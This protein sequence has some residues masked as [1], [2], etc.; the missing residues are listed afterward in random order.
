MAQAGPEAS[1]E[2]SERAL[3]IRE[4]Q[5]AQEQAGQEADPNHDRPHR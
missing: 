2:F 3:Q 5:Q 1:G 4:R